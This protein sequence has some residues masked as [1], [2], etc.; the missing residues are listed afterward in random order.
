M[1]KLSERNKLLL[2]EG[3]HTT[4]SMTD[5]YWYAEE[6]LY[7]HEAEELL[8]FCK[9]ID[10]N[11]G[12]CASGNIDMLFQAWKHPENKELQKSAEELKKRIAEF[13]IL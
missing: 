3:G 6:R 11:I 9:W 5:G 4:G 8:M 12:G 7:I 1:K 10:K 2:L 13:K